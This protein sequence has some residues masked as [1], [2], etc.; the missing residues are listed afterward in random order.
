MQNWRSVTGE[1]FHTIIGVDEKHRLLL[2]GELLGVLAPSSSM[3]EE[4]FH[5]RMEEIVD[6][7][8][9]LASI[10]ARSR[11][12]YGVWDGPMQDRHGFTV[13]GFPLDAEW[14]D[15]CGGDGSGKVVDMVLSP[16]LVKFGNA[17]GQDY[18]EHVILAKANIISRL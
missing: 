4:D 2:I 15:E 11:A 12:H 7:T 5:Q 3:P 10:F 6:K 14:M 9:E 18:D 16:A 8:L 17:E 13:D 1:I